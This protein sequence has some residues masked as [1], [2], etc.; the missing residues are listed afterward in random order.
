MKKERSVATKAAC[1][2]AAILSV[3]LGIVCALAQIGWAAG[4]FLGVA[5]GFWSVRLKQS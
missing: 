4:L 1:V 3:L 2:S 5:W